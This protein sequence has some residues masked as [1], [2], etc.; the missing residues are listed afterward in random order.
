[1]GYDTIEMSNFNLQCKS[2][3]RTKIRVLFRVCHKIQRRFVA[4]FDVL[5]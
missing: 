5:T 1:M 3:S 4:F 2:E